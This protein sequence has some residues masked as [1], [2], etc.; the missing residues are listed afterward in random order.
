M[1]RILR[2]AVLLGGAGGDPLAPGAP[3]PFTWDTGPSVNTPTF[4]A[5]FDNTKV[6]ASGSI[7]GSNYD[8]I[9]LQVDT[10]PA[11]GS[12]D[13]ANNVLDAAELL[14]GTAAFTTGPVPDG[15][16]YARARHNHVVAGGDHFSAWSVT[17][18]KTI[19]A[20]APTLSSATGTKTGQTTADISVSTNEANG[21]LYYVVDQNTTTPSAAQVKAGQDQGGGA[22]DKSGSLAISSTGVKP[23]SITGLTAG[24]TYK[25]YFMHE[26]AN[27]NQS[28]VA[29][30]STFATDSSYGAEALA[31]FAA[32]TTPPDT[33]RK[34]HINTAIEALKTAG[35]WTKLDGLYL[36]AA[37]DSQAAL[38]NWTVPGT[39]NASL[40]D[41]PTFA[42]DRGFTTDGV[43]DSINL[44]DPSGG[45]LQFAQNSA[46]FALWS[47]TIGQSAGANGVTHGVSSGFINPRTTTDLSSYRI[48]DNTSTTT[49]NTDGTGLFHATR[50]GSTASAMYRNGAAHSSGSVASTGVTTGVLRLG[51]NNAGFNTHQFAAAAVGSGFT[52]GEA[53]SFYNA[54]LAYMQAVGAA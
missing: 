3:D 11:F 14:A 5:D 52:S 40:V 18:S 43:N 44:F 34:G 24:T 31:V 39:R 36:F 1:K 42:A 35:V 41:V 46:S 54:L 28:T 50:T 13:L 53:T 22:A 23:F 2:D 8:D 4:T 32:F 33:T 37:A 49:A 29:A 19:D 6:W 15:P 21:T 25:A 38:I 20:T 45:G 51:F 26:D 7:D 16:N 48:N 9:E 30:S 47:R 10:D 12:P 17:A 27:G